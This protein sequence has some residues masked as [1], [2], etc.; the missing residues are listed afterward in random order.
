[1][2][3]NVQK[4]TDKLASGEYAQGKG[5]LL[6]AGRYC[7]LG[8]ACEVSEIGRWIKAGAVETRHVGVTEE[9]YYLPNLITDFFGLETNTGEFHITND[10]LLALDTLDANRVIKI[11]KDT[12]VSIP[13]ATTSYKHSSLVA[14]NDGGVSFENIGWMISMNPPKLF[15]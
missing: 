12:G 9:A 5:A 14:L 6:E 1:M 10:W 3:E 13:S 4:W 11:M 7:C 8:V 15:K 2:N